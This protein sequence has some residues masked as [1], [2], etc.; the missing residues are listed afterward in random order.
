MRC[1]HGPEILA[2]AG[3]QTGAKVM[4]LIPGGGYWTGLFSASVGLGAVMS[5]PSGRQNT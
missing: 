1:A 4:D 2:F 3:V 5:T